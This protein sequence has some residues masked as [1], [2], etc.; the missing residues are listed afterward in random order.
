MSQPKVEVMFDCKACGVS[1]AKLP[2][3]ERASGEDI[4]RWIERVAV[5]VQK[6]HAILSPLCRE[7]KADIYLPVSQ[8][9]IGV[10]GPEL[11]EQEKASIKEQLKP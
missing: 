10:P 3:P 5:E 11:T 7:R 9:G 1:R 8:A 4:E 6:R 2:A